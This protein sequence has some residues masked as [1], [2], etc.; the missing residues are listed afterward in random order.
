MI[1]RCSVQ[2][3]LLFIPVFTMF[4][5]SCASNNQQ[6]PQAAPV[7]V[8]FIVLDSSSTEVEKKYPG[9][10]EGI[11]N[12][13]IKA[14]VS[15]YL[16]QIYIKEGD[17]VQKGQAL[18]KIK[19]DVFNE[20]VKNSRAAYESALA[21]E[22]NAQIELEK[23][24]PLVEGKV[25]TE[26]QLK[27]AEANYAAAKAL[28]A[29]AKAA[30][31]SSQ[32]NAAFSLINA[33]VSGYIGRI[34]NRVGNLVTPAD[35]APLTTLSEINNVYVYF[36]LSEADFIAFVKNRN[37]NTEVNTVELVM[38]DGILYAGKGKL[39]IASGNID[40]TTG[41]ISLKAVFANPDK[42]LRS[43]GSGKIILKNAI[44]NALI[45]PIAS[46]R[47]IQ[48]KY[49]VFTLGDSSKVTMKAIEISGKSGNS[50]IVKKGLAIGEKLALN[51]IDVLNEGIQVTPTVK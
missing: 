11:V 3:M 23:F 14:Q 40:R 9:S 22:Q 48:D 45:I 17:Y 15:G 32:I 50:Y 41:S 35:A 7:D 13:D 27:T 24:K 5:I 10:I 29:H 46:V 6:A 51:R 20:Q 36:S 25:Y 1:R 19:G 37:T 31:G 44:N 21:A 18:F 8:D 12:V 47:D 33:P 30:L 38:A 34:P 43:G 4:L 39:E 16:D 49:F 2:H 42:I 28:A 26:L